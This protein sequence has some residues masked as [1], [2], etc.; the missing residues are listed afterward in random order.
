MKRAYL[1]AIFLMATVLPAWGQPTVYYKVRYTSVAPTVRMEGVNSSLYF[2]SHESLF[3]SDDYELLTQEQEQERKAD[4]SENESGNSVIRL[5]FAQDYKGEVYR[6]DFKE[7]SILFPS[8]FFQNGREVSR[9]VRESTGLMS[10][11]LRDGRKAFGGLEAHEAYCEFRG[12]EYQAWY[13][14]SIPSTAGPWKFNGLPG[15]IVEVKDSDNKVMFLFHS[16][17]QVKEELP[18]VKF[19]PNAPTVS[20]REYLTLHLRG[21][22]ELIAAITSKSSRTGSTGGATIKYGGRETNYDDVK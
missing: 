5:S 8:T 17:E 12:R 14:P 11:E 1:F 19:P 7:Q 3:V 9:I 10:W 6:T 22:Q 16:I 4:V 2:N 15:L 13:V 20:M 18:E 21:N